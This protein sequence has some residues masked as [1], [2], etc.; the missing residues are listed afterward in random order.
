[1]I[2]KGTYSSVGHKQTPD[3]SARE[4]R[5]TKPLQRGVVE[6]AG[7]KD[8]GDG[9]DGAVG[10]VKPRAHERLRLGVEGIGV[11]DDHHPDH[12]DAEAEAGVELSDEGKRCVVRCDLYEIVVA[13][14]VVFFFLF[15]F[16]KHERQELQTKG[17]LLTYCQSKDSE[18]K[19]RPSLLMDPPKNLVRVAPRSPVACMAARHADELC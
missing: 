14:L 3:K 12:A 7:F 5:E 4:L 19:P 6:L 8:L 18:N 10:R 11:P 1:M 2:Q 13:W 15:F 16:Q 17:G 9:I